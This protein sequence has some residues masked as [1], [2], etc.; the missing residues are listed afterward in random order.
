MKKMI[1]AVLVL[2][3][4]SAFA[5]WQDSFPSEDYSRTLTTNRSVCPEVIDGT[6]KFP[7]VRTHGIWDSTKVYRHVAHCQQQVQCNNNE[8]MESWPA[9]RKLTDSEQ[10]MGDDSYCILGVECNCVSDN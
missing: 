2:F 5:E 6:V 7:I 8:R 4:G 10:Q 3:S 1:L 9:L